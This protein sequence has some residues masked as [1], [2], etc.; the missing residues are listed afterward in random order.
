MH[1]FVEMMV[2]EKCMV[3]KILTLVMLVESRVS[4]TTQWKDLVTTELVVR[5]LGPK[6]FVYQTLKFISV[7]ILSFELQ[8]FQFLQCNLS[9][10]LP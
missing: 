6:V 1:V 7:L 5:A 9:L 3:K 8:P 4:L 10:F 2:T